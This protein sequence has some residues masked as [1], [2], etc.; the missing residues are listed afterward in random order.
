MMPQHEMHIPQTTEPPYILEFDIC[1]Y[2]LDTAYNLTLRGVDEQD[3]SKGFF[4]QARSVS[5]D[6]LRGNFQPVNTDSQRRECG[7]N[8]AITHTTNNSKSSVIVTWTSPSTDVG[9]IHFL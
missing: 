9:E 5:D 3:I 4:I 6:Q 7:E 2:D 8:D 1:C